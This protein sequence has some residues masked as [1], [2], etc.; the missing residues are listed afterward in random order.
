[1]AT[2]YSPAGNLGAQRDA[3]ASRFFKNKIKGAGTGSVAP[4]SP[5]S[6]VRIAAPDGCCVGEMPKGSNT[7]GGCVG[8]C[9]D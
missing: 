9:T 3:E 6:K 2:K 5:P 4:F 7:V 8:G 1:M